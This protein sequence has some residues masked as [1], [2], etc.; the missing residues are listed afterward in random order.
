MSL[1]KTRVIANQADFQR[2]NKQRKVFFF[3]A[4]FPIVLELGLIFRKGQKPA[5]YLH[6][7]G[8]SLLAG[9]YLPRSLKSLI[10]V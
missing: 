3:E 1:R 6:Q 7:R 8:I 2:T 10:R 9:M 4:D 5:A